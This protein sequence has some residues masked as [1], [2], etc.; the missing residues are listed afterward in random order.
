MR[1]LIIGDAHFRSELPYASSFKDGRRG[2]WEDV[3]NAILEAAKDCDNVVLMGDN[4]NS[5]N[6]SST[7]LRE[8][9]EF[10][11]G[12]GDKQVYVLCGNH[13][14]SGGVTA[15]DFLDRMKHPN[16]HVYTEPAQ[17]DMGGQT[18]MMIPY[19]TPGSLGVK[20]IAEANALVSR[21]SLP[22]DYAFAHHTIQGTTWGGGS[23]EDVTKFEVTLP[24][25]E[26]KKKFGL[27]FAGHI[28]EKQKLDDRV[29]VVGS[30]F[31]SEVGEHGKSVWIVDGGAVKEIPLPVRPIYKV[32]VQQAKSYAYI[33]KN[34]IVKAVVSDPFFNNTEGRAS[35][36][37]MFA[38]VDALLIVESYP[39]QR[40]K[41]H[42]EEGALD[43]SVENMLK[44]YAE[45]R[46]IDLATLQH[47]FDILRK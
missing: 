8:F 26:M 6:N 4:L 43:L 12:F 9:V 30:M 37:E 45:A 40:E 32:N 38:H 17:V 35:I 33:P 25:E 14:R 39:R 20:D 10:L 11:K 42:F 5:R 13:E 27:S 2:E 34:A 29:F 31:T 15:I 36:R 3:K 7:V 24:L 23:W 18:A 46:K 16:W 21:V 44:V 19:V 28:H 22:S 47:G 1:T 41:M